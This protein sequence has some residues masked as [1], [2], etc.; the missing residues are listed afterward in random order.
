[1][2]SVI[3]LKEGKLI[4]VTDIHG[5]LN[6]FQ[7]Y[8]EIWR[9]YE[10]KNTVS[11][12]FTGDLIHAMTEMENDKSIEILELSM[13]LIK[14]DGFIILLGNHEWSHIADISVYKGFRNQ[15]KE[16]IENL[17]MKFQ[18][19]W[20]DKFDE[21]IKFF[22]DLPIALKTGNGVFISH[23]GP[24]I[25][26][27]SLKDIENSIDKGYSEFNS[28]LYGLLW[29]RPYRDY[30]EYDVEIF[31]DKIKCN[32]M[33]VGHTPVD[34]IEIFGDKQLILSSSFSIGKKAYIVLDLEKRIENAN[35]LLKFVRYLN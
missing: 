11:I 1:M 20:S 28:I 6:D 30:S 35:D 4:V 14:N 24:P 31:L 17:K 25:G 33:I 9:K 32:A 23:A 21:Y 5:N 18:E 7:R 13:S 10:N 2:K 27:N 34:G 3:E 16:F 15:S 8:I 29:N 26:I 19:K 22:H 12:V